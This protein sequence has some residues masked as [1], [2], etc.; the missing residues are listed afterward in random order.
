[1]VIQVPFGDKTIPV[2]LP[3]GIDVL[4]MREPVCIENPHQ[5]IC[6]A[7]ENPIGSAPLRVIARE[8]ALVA[9]ANN[10]QARACIVIS[11]QTRPVPYAGENGLLNP[12]LNVLQN[13][14]LLPENICI[15]IAC[16]TH[17]P[18]DEQ[19]IR[20]MI[21][22]DVYDSG[23]QVVNHD[24]RNEEQLVTIGRTARGTTVKINRL[25]VDADVKILTGLVESHF[26]AGAS[27]GRKSVC[28][29]IFGEEGTFVFHGP[30]LMSHPN[31]RDLVLEGNPVH[32]ESLSV[33]KLAGVDF[34]ANVTLNSEFKIT[35]VFCGDLERAHYAAVDRIKEY[36]AIPI[37]EPYDFVIT[38]GGFVALNH[39]Q[40]A[41]AAV[42]AIS[43]VKGDGVLLQVA[44]N[45]DKNA[46]G[47]DRYRVVLS[48]LKTMGAK[49]LERLLF[50]D[51]WQFMPDQWQVQLWA[52]VFKHMDVKNYIYYAPQLDEKD[53]RDIP[54]NNGNRYLDIDDQQKPVEQKIALVIQAALQEFL[55]KRG[56]TPEDILDRT[57]RVAFLSEGPYG[58]PVR[59]T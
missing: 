2:E 8:H 7:L 13:E 41:K 27:G 17:R 18:M 42:A 31:A 28:P 14:G 55:E 24:C 58:I 22:S 9:K 29:G 56:F 23:V 47:S 30:E 20:R 44:N 51:A 33:A 50:S 57:C 48:L 11:D 15:L 43:A 52:R 4:K 49:G 6:T 34:I 16:G 26:M 35:G 38:H 3:D 39:Y 37:T 5:A 19:E 21:G 45:Y 36:V 46:I 59:N 40:A 12:I 54:G 10:R 1:M 32:E 53:W 25:Y